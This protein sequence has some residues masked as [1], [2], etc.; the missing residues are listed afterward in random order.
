MISASSTTK[1]GIGGQ[2]HQTSLN[3]VTTETSNLK[4]PRK[5][6][7]MPAFMISQVTVTNKEK[8][9]SY[10]AKTRTIVAKYGAKP[11]AIGTHPKM[12]NGESDGHQRVVVIE[13][14]T[15]E[16]IDVWHSSDEYQAIV[17]L[18]EEGSDQRMVAYEGKVMSPS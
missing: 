15:M 12:L 17:S 9:E 10:L 1:V 6:I 2:T 14:P 4:P 18:R 5:E 8:F 16:K 3:R 7:P 13:F 11:V